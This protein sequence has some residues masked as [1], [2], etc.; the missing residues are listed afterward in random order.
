MKPLVYARTLHGV[1]LWPCTEGVACSLPERNVCKLHAVMKC[2]HVYGLLWFACAHLRRVCPRA[3]QGYVL[4]YTVREAPEYM[5]CLQNGKYDNADRMF[6]SIAD[7]WSG[8]VVWVKAS[9]KVL[10]A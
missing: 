2:T 1:L 4:F 5:L 9:L 6:R 8:T 7:T 10:P 3:R